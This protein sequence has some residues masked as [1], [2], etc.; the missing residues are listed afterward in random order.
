MSKAQKQKIAQIAIAAVIFVIAHFLPAEDHIQLAGYLVAYFIVGFEVLK[1]AFLNLFRGQVFDENLL[2][3]IAT[4]GAFAI[5]QYPEGV[6][7]MLFAQVG[8]FFEHYAV[9]RSRE[10]ISEMMN[11]QPESANVYR[12]GK[13]VTVDPEDVQIDEVILI[14][15]GEKVPLDGVIIDGTSS[16]ETKALTGEAMPQSVNVGDQ[17]LSGCINQG[18]TLKVKVTKLYSDSTVAKILEL[19]ENAASQKAP[20]ER[21]ITKF[22]RYYT[23][24]VVIAALA[25]AFVPPLILGFDVFS[26]W[27]R[28]ALI[29]LVISCPCALVISIPL[30]F[31]SGIGAAAKE[32]ILVKGSNYLEVL[33]KCETAVFD[34]TGTLTKG[35][36][37]ID[38]IITAQG[39]KDEILK[40]AA[41]AESYSNHPLAE[42]VRKGYGQEI[43]NAQVV[44][45]E[46]LPGYGVKTTTA[47]HTIYAGNAKL[48]KSLNLDCPE[49]HASAVYVAV[50]DKYL[51]VI[52]FN[53]TIKPEAVSALHGLKAMGVQDT[54]IL[55]GDKKA[56]AEKVGQELGVS[57]VYSELLP[58]DKVELFSKLKNET[59]EKGSIIY[60][61]DGINDAPVLALADCGI[62]MGAM[63]SDAAIEA[64][65]IVIMDD[66]IQKIPLVVALAKKT[67]GIVR[68]NI[69]FALGIKGIFL[70]LGAFGLANMWE[71]VFADVG[72][73]V[74]AIANSMRLLNVEKLKRKYE[75]MTA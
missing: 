22:A 8:E 37:A 40:W 6:F 10:S 41:L 32:G 13:L 75:K 1:D 36:F 56:A 49:V 42:A 69:I 20:T 30:G 55:S 39:S 15:P 29:F 45:N 68:G 70:I 19:V 2:M 52:T 26:E 43:D 65:D 5:G 38:E 51:G 18:G 73:S 9:N 21:F 64:A 58:A 16:L 24:A 33:A 60:T 17:V 71:A 66:N 12:E 62:A 44:K 57:H 54:V 34:K 14:A 25:L 63:G 50:D 7:V 35:E 4:I 31:F 27:F 47:E 11:I 46:E 74:I 3:S 72:V 53:D 67:A 28:R 59:S 61:G 23:P 48:M